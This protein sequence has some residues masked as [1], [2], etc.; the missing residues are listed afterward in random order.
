MGRYLD[1]AGE[2]GNPLQGLSLENSLA[3]ALATTRVPVAAVSSPTNYNFSAFGLGEPLTGPTMEAFGALGALSAPS[4]ALAQ[5]RTASLNTNLIRNQVAPFAE[6]EGKLPFTSP[7]TYPTNGAN[8][9][10]GWRRSLRC[11]PTKRCDQMRFAE[12]GRRLRHPLG[13]GRN[14]RHEPQGDRRIG[15]R[16]PARPGSTQ[17]RRPGDHPAVVGVRPSAAGKRLRHRPRR[18]RRLLPD[19]QPGQRRNGRRIPGLTKLDRTKT[20][21]T[22]VTSGGLRRHPRAVVQNRSGPGDTGSRYG[23]RRSEQIRHGPRAVHLMGTVARR[24]P[25][26]LVLGALTLA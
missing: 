7:V 26:L 1:I 22:H 9:R 25:V 10:S 4:P 8:S 16:L 24:I 14:A 13:R 3:P 12:R 20:S 19:R 11:W 17:N 18:G 21:S 5:A 15:R 6:K 2:P 23:A